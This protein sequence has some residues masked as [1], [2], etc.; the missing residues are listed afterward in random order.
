MTTAERLARVKF[1]DDRG[2]EDPGMRER[3]LNAP[4]ASDEGVWPEP[5][6]LA[7]LA[8][9]K[10]EPPQIIIPDWLPAGYA[11]LL[12]GH[13]GVGKS[14]IGLFLAV[15]IALGRSCFG[16]HTERRRVTYLACEDREGVLHW[17]LARI[18]AYLGVDLTELVGHLFTLDLVGRDSILWAKDPR[19]GYTFT[20]AFEHLTEHVERYR[21][22][23]LWIDGVS[24]AFGGNENARVEVK[25]FVNRLLSVVPIDGALVLIGHIAKPT[26]SGAGGEGYSGS[27]QWHNAVRARWYLFPETEQD[28]DKGRPQRT[29][30]LTLELQKSNHGKIDQAVT[31][32]WE[33]DAHM[34]LPVDT[35]GVSRIDRK[36]RDDGERRGIAHALLGCERA[37]IIVPSASQGK[38]TALNVL[39]LRP[40]FPVALRTAKGRFW[41]QIE[42]LRQIRWIDEIEY[43]R[44]DRHHGA[45]FVLTQEGRGQCGDIRN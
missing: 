24:D 9:R 40:E 10:P 21:P 27:T 38:R 42:A 39:V 20:P 44:K 16:I 25:A 1:L 3:V 34:F 22:E 35:F 45:Q 15:S 37:G 23:V 13:G 4:S 31:F 36:H 6:D 12:A 5:L 17:R 26:A 33:E 41:T 14:A 11:T 19:T 29:G 18:C 7:A 8:R 28:D 32:A 30:K 43:R 2:I